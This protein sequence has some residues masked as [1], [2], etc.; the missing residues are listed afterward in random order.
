MGENVRTGAFVED[1]KSKIGQAV[2]GLKTLEAVKKKS[3]EVGI[4]MP[5]VDSLYSLYLKA[6]VSIQKRKF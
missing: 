5:I 1:A 3:L 2:E 4:T 6:L